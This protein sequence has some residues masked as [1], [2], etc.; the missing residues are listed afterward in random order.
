MTL[1]DRILSWFRK[2]ELTKKEFEEINRS[3]DEDDIQNLV[4]F[5]DDEEDFEEDLE[6][7][8]GAPIISSGKDIGSK[9]IDKDTVEGKRVKPNLEDLISGFKEDVPDKRAIWGGKETIAF[10]KW[11]AENNWD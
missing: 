7:D 8:W 11:K 2:E 4:L 3:L 6:Y 1:K 5:D 9:Y 10:K